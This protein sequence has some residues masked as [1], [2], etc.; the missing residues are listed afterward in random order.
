MRFWA[1]TVSLLARDHDLFYEQGRERDPTLIPHALEEIA[2]ANGSDSTDRLRIGRVIKSE[3]NLLG[4]YA[5]RETAHLYDED[6]TRHDEPSY[7]P[8]VWVW[9]HSEQTLLVQL[10]TRVFF[11]AEAAARGFTSLL[12]PYLAKHQVEVHIYPKV[13]EESF[14]NVTREFSSIQDV[15]F[16]Y[17]TPNLFGKT[18]AEM[19]EFLKMIR[20]S[21]N[22]TVLT[23]KITNTDGHLHP[24]PEGAIARALDWIKDGGGRWSVRGRVTLGARPVT[25]SSGKQASIFVLPDKTVAIKADGYTANDLVKI[26]DSLRNEYTFHKKGE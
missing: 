13:S 25:R 19:T 12:T 23:T 1:L 5:R 6:F 15:T 18:K 17:A 10:D 21:T 24:K 22:A 14:W 16:E 7:P 26:I 2:G 20:D 3:W 8:R 9:D 4:L 11:D